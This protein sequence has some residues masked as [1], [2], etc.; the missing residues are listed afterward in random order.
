MTE[1][2]RRFAFY[3][4]RFTFYVL[5]SFVSIRVEGRTFSVVNG[6]FPLKV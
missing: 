2:R 5:R 3:V 4:L 6:A 1:N